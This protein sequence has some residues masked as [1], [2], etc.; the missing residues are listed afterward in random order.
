[1]MKI[2]YLCS[3][4]KVPARK[5]ILGVNSGSLTC[6]MIEK[7]IFRKNGLRKENPL[8]QGLRLQFYK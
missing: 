7:E 2:M 6:Y 1:M 3:A 4:K 5:S 8:E